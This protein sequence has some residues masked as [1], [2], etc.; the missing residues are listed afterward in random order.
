MVVAASALVLPTPARAATIATTRARDEIVV[1]MHSTYPG[2]AFGNVACPTTVQRAA[3]V[4]FSC[5]VQLPGTFLVIDAT[6]PDTSG[7]V[8]L[9]TTQAVLTK[10]ALESFVA[11]NASLPAK[12][13]CGPVAWIVRH[14]GDVVSC[15]AALT[16][17]T[18][19]TVQLTV[20]D[21]AGN[22]TITGVT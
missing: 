22:V 13:D 21:T 11:A 15:T 9:T 19:R 2:L 5:T 10:P 4:T 3:S 12:V 7:A 8:E 6:Q 18:T 20:R 16:D 17:G 14:P 1:L